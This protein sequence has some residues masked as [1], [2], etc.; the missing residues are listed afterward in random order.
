VRVWLDR[1]VFHNIC[2]NTMGCAVRL[3]GAVGQQLPGRGEPD[4]SADAVTDP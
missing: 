3:G 1:A 2:H 4:P